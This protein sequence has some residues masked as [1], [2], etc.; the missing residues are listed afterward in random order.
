MS[1][2]NELIMSEKEIKNLINLFTAL[3]NLLYNSEGNREIARDMDISSTIQS[4]KISESDHDSQTLKEIH[5]YL[6]E[7]LK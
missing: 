5:S 2:I 1:L 7:T 6:S 3:G 4:V